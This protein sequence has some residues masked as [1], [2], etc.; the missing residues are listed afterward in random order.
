[1]I[2]SCIKKILSIKFQQINNHKTFLLQEKIKE[3]Y[4]V[5]PYIDNTAD[6]FIKEFKIILNFKLAFYG[7]NKLNKFIKVHKD[8]LLTHPRMWYIKSIV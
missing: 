6:K 3:N 4:F 7:I 2:F 1:M 8:I 5:F